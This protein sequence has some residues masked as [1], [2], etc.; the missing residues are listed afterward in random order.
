M[1]TPQGERIVDQLC[2]LSSPHFEKMLYD[3]AQL[4]SAYSN[5]YQLTK[6]ERYANVARDI[7]HYCNRDLAHPE[8]AYYSAEDADS[9]PTKDAPEKIGMLPVEIGPDFSFMSVK[10]EPLPCGRMMKS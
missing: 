1:C 5:A 6:E 8:G 10:R 2:S 3:Q 7:L 4:L 9:K